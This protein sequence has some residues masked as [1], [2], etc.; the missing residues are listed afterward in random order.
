[1]MKSNYGNIVPILLLSAVIT[2]IQPQESAAQETDSETGLIKENGWLLVRSNCTACHSP[3][4]ITQNS[5]NRAVW[6]SRI[7]WM[8]QTQGLGVLVPEVE[9][10]ILDYLATHYGQKQ[11]SRRAPLAAHLLPPD[12]NPLE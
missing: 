1:M 12:S 4:L 6:E 9:N 10:Q 5:G 11:S 2:A 3:L 7:R 8:Q